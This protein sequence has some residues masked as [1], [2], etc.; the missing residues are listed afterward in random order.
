MSPPMAAVALVHG[1]RGD[2]EGYALWRSRAIEVIG[3]LPPHSTLFLTM[4]DA[5]LAVHAGRV[6]DA[7]ALVRLAF[8]DVPSWWSPPYS[9]AV[10]A[11]LAVVAGL[12]DAPD[13]LSAA[14]RHESVWAVACTA[15]A[16]GRLYG[17]IAA[18][19]A[20]VAGW[21]RIGARFERASTLLLLPDRAAEGRRELAALGVEVPALRV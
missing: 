3:E 10:G 19:T 4:V 16:R 21:E 1:L 5:R 14:E 15:R 7:A 6:E 9:R 12:S 17:D 8:A 18:L 13:L 2:D 20:A 11:E